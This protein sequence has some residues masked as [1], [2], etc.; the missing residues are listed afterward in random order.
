[1]E[2]VGAEGDA[3]W[4]AGVRRERAALLALVRRRFERLRARRQRIG[5][6]PDGPDLDIAAVVEAHADR[7]AGHTGDE[8]LYQTV[9][10]ERR[11]VAVALLADVSGSTDSW[12]SGS[13]RVID[14]EREALIVVAHALEALGDPFAIY[15][16]SGEGPAR[17]DVRVVKSFHEHAGG[18][19]DRRVAALHPER[20]TRMGAAFRH[21]SARL[22]QQPARH[23][24]LLVL[25]DGKPNDVDRYEGR[26][27]IE[28]ARQAVAEA[29][30]QGLHP[31][32]LTVDREAPA[33]LPR[34][35]GPGAYTVLRRA[36][37]LPQ[38]LVDVV[39]RLI[40]D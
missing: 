33:Y 21:A 23:R 3:A 25:S 26:Y 15:A 31:F 32:C 11:D 6:Q 20:Y 29:R 34:I 27:G 18:A 19:V 12:V 24:L 8:R 22:I 30:L 16:F 35:F 1:V 14:V 13:R 7:R 38:A 4:G 28:D 39:R 40:R 10:P 17:V 9:R 36:H 5:R 37:T 2:A